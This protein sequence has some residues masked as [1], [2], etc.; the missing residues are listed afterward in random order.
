MF[1]S[2]DGGE[3]AEIHE[4]YTLG[5][6]DRAVSHKIKLSLDKYNIAKID[7]EITTKY[8]IQVVPI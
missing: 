2:D 1:Y 3:T 5:T 6:F 8:G 7:Q 4:A